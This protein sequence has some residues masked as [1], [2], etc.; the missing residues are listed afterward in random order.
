MTDDLVIPEKSKLTNQ[1]YVTV[2]NLNFNVAIDKDKPQKKL[3][4]ALD[5]AVPKDETSGEVE[6]EL[7]AVKDRDDADIYFAGEITRASGTNFVGSV[8]TKLQYPICCE[9]QH[10]ITPFFD[11]RANSDPEAD[12]DS[13]KFG[14]MWDWRFYRSG[15]TNAIS[16]NLV[17]SSWQNTGKIESERD[18]DNTNFLWDTRVQFLSK[19]WTAR[20]GNVRFWLDPFVGAELGKNLKSPVAEAD[21]Q[22]LAR[23]LVGSRLNFQWELGLTNLDSITLESSYIRRILLKREVGFEK[24]EDDSLRAVNFGTNPR[25]WA[26]AKLAFNVRKFFGLYIGYE[27]GE[28]PPSYKLVDHRMKLGLLFRTVIKNK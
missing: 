24:A 8:D 13:V 21:G 17:G 15:G 23:I 1:Y 7:K 5:F 22:G 27:Y 3:T 6:K 28:Q 20:E 19:V 9:A 2:S 25:Q 16:R 11:L 12:P 26:E 18:F 4:S 14:L 10:T